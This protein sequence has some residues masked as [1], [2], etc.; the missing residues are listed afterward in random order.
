MLWKRNMTFRRYPPFPQR[1][2]DLVTH[3]S[4]L[5]WC[6]YVIHSH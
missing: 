3:N 1:H 4:T 5:L 2:L 6:R